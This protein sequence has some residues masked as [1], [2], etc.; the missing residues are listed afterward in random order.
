MCVNTS[1]INKILDKLVYC[2][3]DNKNHT[4]R[5]CYWCLNYECLNCGF[6]REV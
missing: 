4:L 5:F 6:Q 3:S 2:G 1:D